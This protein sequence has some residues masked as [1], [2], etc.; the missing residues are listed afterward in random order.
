VI[1]GLEAAYERRRVSP[2][3]KV[4]VLSRHAGEAYAAQAPRAG[5]AGY[6]LKGD[7]EL[8]MAIKPVSLGESNRTVHRSWSV[9]ASTI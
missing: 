7:D 4:L 8:P 5:V 9:S 1:D 6:L 3:T 2:R